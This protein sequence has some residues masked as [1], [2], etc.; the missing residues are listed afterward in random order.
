M[1]IFLF[2]IIILLFFIIIITN[3]I[4]L[5]LRIIFQFN[6]YLFYIKIYKN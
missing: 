1:T 6:L 5:K 3:Y 4:Y 2:K